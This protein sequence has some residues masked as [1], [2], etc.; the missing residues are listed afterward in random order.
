[1]DRLKPIWVLAGGAVAALG[2]AAV[3][4]LGLAP[5]G[6][7]TPI[8]P[9]PQ[10]AEPAP[11]AESPPETTAPETTTGERTGDAETTEG[12]QDAASPEIA[13][14]PEKPVPPRPDSAPRDS[15]AALPEAPATKPQTP[16]E[17]AAATA[18]DSDSASPGPESAPAGAAPEATVEKPAS[19]G[20]ARDAASSG[21]TAADETMSADRA[22]PTPESESESE[23]AAPETTTLFGIALPQ[24]TDQEP[25]REEAPAPASAA[26]EADSDPARESAPAPT[27]DPTTAAAAT[28]PTGDTGVTGGETAEPARPDPPDPETP[29]APSGERADSDEAARAD[30]SAPTR[31]P[32]RFD[33]VRV[34]PGG[35]ALIA[36]RATPHSEV[37]VLAD[38]RP[39]GTAT[40]NHLGEFV[41][42]P[43]KNL[44]QA[45]SELTLESRAPGGTTTKS[46]TAVIIVRPPPGGQSP[47]SSGTGSPG[48]TANPDSAGTPDA[49]AAATPASPLAASQSDPET[50]AA[51]GSEPLETPA[52]AR[53]APA[54]PDPES[55]E[56]SPAAAPPPPAET[57]MALLVPREGAGASRLLQAPPAAQAPDPA[58]GDRAEARPPALRIQI[59]QY[60]TDGG[61]VVSG[62]GPP[63]RTAVVRLDDRTLG[64]IPI[65]EAG[66]WR[67]TWTRPVAPG[68]Y[69]LKATALD[70]DGTVL[71][72]AQTPFA[73]QPRLDADP[74]ARL[75]VV[76]PG[77]N[78]W[79]LARR[80]YGRGV[81][82]TTIYHANA[83]QIA[84]PDLIYPG[85][86]FVVPETPAGERGGPAPPGQE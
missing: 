9:M 48:K 20:P 35:E 25:A 14:A 7:D 72:K 58:P 68:L 71:A 46:E 73:S 60:T 83:D 15:D 80:N 81:Q 23:S 24:W 37:T 70:A 65:D 44:A 21:T 3:V 26:S 17:T 34:E 51:P 11:E 28:R 29:A 52:G 86:V 74:D 62:Q 32:P 50:A 16:A 67:V 2:V 13:Q 42:L 19:A 30:P 55:A 47:P 10:V 31:H 79:T 78:L 6:G 41:L 66:R 54:A 57:P 82:Y 38:D 8:P 59:V 43:D 39:I 76:Q 22:A 63:G 36:G 84:D 5:D 85:Q 64:R 49:P 75:V 45:R 27:A 1:V 77:H 18:S 12:A 61:L 4:Y 53:Q 69:T 56:T 40:A 33:I